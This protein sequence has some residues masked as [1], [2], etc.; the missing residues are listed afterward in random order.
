[1][2]RI[3]LRALDR[4][5]AGWS[6]S[7]AL[8]SEVIVR[9]GEKAR[10][11]KRKIWIATAIATGRAVIGGLLPLRARARLGRLSDPRRRGQTPPRGDRG[12]EAMIEA[13]AV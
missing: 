13:A 11:I 10:N 8:P 12:G 2:G 9:W 3:M 7:L 5:R 6:P 4:V 1:M